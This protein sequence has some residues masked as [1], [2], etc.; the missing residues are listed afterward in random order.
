M[1]VWASLI[2]QLTKTPPAMQEIQFD[3][4]IKKILWRRDRLSTP[5]SLGFPYGS[6]GKDSVSNVRDPSLIPE[7]GRSHGEGKGYTL[8]YFGLENFVDCIIFGVVKSWTEQSNFHFHFH[9]EDYQHVIQRHKVS[10]YYFKNV[11]K[12]PPVCRVATCLQFVN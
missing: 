6:A 2:A 9:C 8:Q 4:W 12:K 7:L 10:K 1:R 5:V 3:T 11:T